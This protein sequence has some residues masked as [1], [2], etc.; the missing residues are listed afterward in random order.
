[1]AAVLAIVS[2]SARRAEAQ[3]S[4]EPDTNQF[5]DDNNL[6]E[7]RLS[8]HSDD[9]R[10]LKE[11]YLENTYYPA[12]FEW[13]GLKVRNVGIRS[14]GTAS[15]SSTKPGLRVD[16]DR[17]VG[18][19]RF[20]G[21]KSFVLDNLV[22]DPSFIKERLSMRMF[23]QMGLPAPRETH[24]RLYVN[25]EYVG[26]YALVESIDKDF[27][28]RA[29]TA[30]AQET[31]N[32]ERDGVIFEYNHTFEYFFSYLG[33][34]L[35]PYGQIFEPKTHESD[36]PDTL[37]GPIRDMCRLVT[38]SSDSDFVDVVS[39][40]IDLQEF[41]RYV[42]VENFVADGDGI[43]G[44]AGMN[45]FYL[46]RLENTNV[47][48]FIP[49]DKDLAFDNATR[50]IWENADRNTLMQRAMNVPALRALYLD[51]LRNAAA[52]ASA[53]DGDDARG[54]LEREAA[55]EVDQIRAWAESDSLKPQ[56]NEAFNAEL[57]KVRDIARTRPAFVTCQVGNALDPNN[58]KDCTPTPPAATTTA[59]RG[60]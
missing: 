9:W 40:F 36:S 54:W 12:D 49:W 6:Q 42:A 30:R 5:F 50:S 3:E 39:G 8:I 18:D 16:L 51:T 26:L 24:A 2:L 23:A 28:E 1:M 27:I 57:D 44:F 43:L 41:V 59:K 45:N 53:P 15:R 60:G 4:P 48:Q 32:K 46:Y 13:N 14:R 7:V 33:P 56:T 10:R 17:Y 20:L 47:S 55:R 22:Q 35:D 31:G 11:T 19:Q 21:L 58:Q 25:N 34:E 29:Y 37:Y 52:L 38:E